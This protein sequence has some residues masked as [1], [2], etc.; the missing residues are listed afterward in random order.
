LKLGKQATRAVLLTAVALAVASAIAFVAPATAQAA[1]ANARAGCSGSACDGKDPQVHCN[2]DKKTVQSLRLGG[3]ALLELRYSRA[4]RAAWAKIS[5]ADWEPY[6]T[7]ASW[8]VIHRN[9]DGREFRCTVPST[10]TECYTPMVN[11]AGVT[12]YARGFWDSGAQTYE[13]RTG[14]YFL[15]TSS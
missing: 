5:N 14:S 3:T 11:D 9:S 1:S 7:F 15:E 13:D 4:C 2:S 12:S 6:S 8:A 10:G